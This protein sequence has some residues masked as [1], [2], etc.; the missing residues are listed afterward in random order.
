MPGWY[1]TVEST[2]AKHLISQ[3]KDAI[4]D[5]MAS[6]K[7]TRAKMRAVSAKQRFPVARWVEE[8][9]DLHSTSIRKSEKHRDKPSHLTISNISKLRTSRAP[10][11]TFSEDGRPVTPASFLS[12]AHS[13]LPSGA[14]S[15]GLNPNGWP[16]APPRMSHNYRFSNASIESITKGRTDFALQKVDPFFTDADGEYTEEFIKMLQDL[17]SKNSETELCIEQYLVQS[18]KK[19][20]EDYKSVKFGLGSR[21]ASKVSLSEHFRGPSPTP[22]PMRPS[23]FLET[24]TRPHS[25]YAPS[26]ASSVSDY[27]DDYEPRPTSAHHQ[28]ISTFDPP[29]SPEPGFGPG[30]GP[31]Q[32]MATPLQKFMMRKIF[33]WPVYALILA[34]GQILGANSYQISLLNGEQ[35]QTASM[36]YTIASIYA[37]SSILWWIGFRNLKSVWVLAMPFGVYGL[38]F[39]FV[40]LS[41]F[42]A[43]I[44]ARGWLQ[45]VGSGLYAAAASSGSM[46]FALNFGDEGKFAPLPVLPCW[47]NNGDEDRMESRS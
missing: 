41:P 3:F 26:V 23:R 2:S 37:I 21:N 13:A 18:E 15:P 35:G 5:A 46:Y 20:F 28:P 33:D 6:D 16:L 8:I 32:V 44:L 30:A 42:G 25:P 38:A 47:M 9:G 10:S 27:G 43:S 19:W 1:Y 39:M 22:T 12:P 7:E 45:K 4:Q 17:D 34:F 11:P 24:P 29:D 40:G 36:L 31:I 14:N